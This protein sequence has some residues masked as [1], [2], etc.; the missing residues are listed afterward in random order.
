MPKILIKEKAFDS[1]VTEH[2]VFHCD[3]FMNTL[4]FFVCCELQ[5]H[6]LPLSYDFHNY[7]LRSMEEEFRDIAGIR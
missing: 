1:G 5:T 7:M 6:E 2:H 4:P 3:K